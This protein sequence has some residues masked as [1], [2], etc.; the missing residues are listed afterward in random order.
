MLWPNLLGLVGM[1]PHGGVNPVM[2][3]GKRQSGVQLLG[4]GS[5]AN[6]QKRGDPRSTRAL[7]HAFTVLGK[8]REVNMRMGVDQFHV[9]DIP[10]S[11]VLR[12]PRPQRTRPGLGG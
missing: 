9:S 10:T 5:R 6:S 7:Q 4:T 2:L 1:N 12:L 3:F 11:T 8:L